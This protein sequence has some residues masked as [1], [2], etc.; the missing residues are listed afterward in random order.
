MDQINDIIDG[1]A[2]LIHISKVSDKIT[3]VTDHFGLFPIY[4]YQDIN[5]LIISTDLMGVLAIRPDLRK[6][7]DEKS[8]VEFVSCHFILENR[9]LFKDIFRLDE[10]TITVFHQVEKTTERKEWLKLPL[11]HED[12]QLGD[13]INL[14]REKLQTSIRKRVTESSGMFL[15][16]GMD[17][18]KNKTQNESPDI[19]SQRC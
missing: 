17:S 7:L 1:E 19:W 14:T 2:V 16:G 11:H 9:T 8:I 12:K 15:S 13:W 10:G 4:Y 5:E 6:K 18:R 3:I